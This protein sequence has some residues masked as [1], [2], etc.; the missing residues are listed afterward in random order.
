MSC[1]A[2]TPDDDGPVL[3]AYDGSEL[4]AHAIT[5]ARRLLGDGRYALVVCVWQPFDVG[6]IAARDLML[7]AEQATEVRAA[8][9]ATADQGVALAETAGFRARPIAHEASPV[10]KGIVELADERDASV[11][12]LGSH[13]RTGIA[14]A[15]LGSVAGAVAARS[16]RTVLISHGQ[17]TEA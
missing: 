1:A 9:E 8:A 17:D 12:V 4:A 3:I 16:A 11:I 5:E 15:L 10:W 7:H 6:F 14:G 2:P 13:G